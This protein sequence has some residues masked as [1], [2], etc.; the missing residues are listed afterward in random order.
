MVE[1]IVELVRLKTLTF[2]EAV[3]ECLRHGY[4]LHIE[5]SAH[6]TGLAYIHITKD[7]EHIEYVDTIIGFCGWVRDIIVEDVDTWKLRQNL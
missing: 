2:T 4:S 3:Q 5:A 7:G 6:E 1:A